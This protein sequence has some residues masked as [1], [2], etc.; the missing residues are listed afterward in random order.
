MPHVVVGGPLH[1]SGRQV[2]DTAADFSVTY[3]DVTSEESLVAEIAN[4]DAVLLRTQPV[5]E[6][7]IALGKNVKIYSRH[8]VGYDAVDVDALNRRGIALAVCGDVNSTTVAEHAS[9]LILGACKRILRGDAAVRGG[10]WEWR[11]KLEGRDIRGRNLLQFG[12]GRIGRHIGARMQVFGMNIRAYDPYLMQAG[13]PKDGVAG[14]ENLDEALQWADVISFSIPHK[15]APLIGGAELAKMRDGVVLVNTARGGI[16]DQTALVDA[17][18][19]GKVSAAGLDV[20]AEEPMPDNNPL[21][22]FDQVVL[23]PHIGGLT[24]DAA[25]RMA[26]SSAENIVNFF[27]GTIDHTLIVNREQIHASHQ[28]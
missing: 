22:G 8:G 3:I 12:Y 13:W 5:S 24:Q 11:N 20:F 17:L 23:S 18:K 21:K 25:A 7:T 2:L 26:I 4:A 6:P 9:M 15:G 27:N 19:S 28:N 16:I 1:P 10:D 14:V